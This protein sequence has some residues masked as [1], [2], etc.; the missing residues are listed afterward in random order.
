VSILFERMGAGDVRATSVSRSSAP[1]ASH[2]ATTEPR[3]AQAQQ[4][5]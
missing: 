1:L 3:V 5:Q 2:S 4:Q